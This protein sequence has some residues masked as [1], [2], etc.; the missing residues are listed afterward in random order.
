MK[1]RFLDA[2]LLAT[3]L[4]A[5]G[6]QRSDPQPSVSKTEPLSVERWRGLEPSVK[7]EFETLEF[8]RQCNS[9]LA[10]ERRWNKFVND[11]VVPE[12]QVDFPAD[13]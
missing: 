9:K 3:V 11:V 8:L 13:Y 5:T 12:R 4:I 10:N 2:M 7:Y 6:C 1:M